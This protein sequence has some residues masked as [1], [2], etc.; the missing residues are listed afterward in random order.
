M[1]KWVETKSWEEA[2]HSIVP[3]RKFHA[4]KK[5]KDSSDNV[6]ADVRQEGVEAVSDEE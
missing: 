6:D 4:G 2:L 5:N 1:V 3:K